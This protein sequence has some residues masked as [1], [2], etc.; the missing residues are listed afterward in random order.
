MSWPCAQ[1]S[2]SRAV[3][4]DA[5]PMS[6]P[7]QGSRASGPALAYPPRRAC[8]AVW[9]QASSSAALRWRYSAAIWSGKSSPRPASAAA[10][11]R[12]RSGS[13]MDSSVVSSK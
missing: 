6:S 3:T 5:S 7:Y 2:I 12:N 9:N 8:R 4:D 10:S 1:V 13:V 11:R